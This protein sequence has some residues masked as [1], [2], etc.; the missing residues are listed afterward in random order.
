MIPPPPPP[1]FRRMAPRPLAL[2]LAAAATTLFASPGALPNSKPGSPLS[3]R[4]AAADPELA[5]ALASAEPEALA[6]ALRREILA[7]AASFADGIARYRAHPWRRPAA[8][9]PEIWREGTTRLFDGAPGS[10]GAPVLLVPSLVNRAHILDLLPD[11]SFLRALAQAGLRPMLVDWDRPGATERGWGL[12]DYIA[13]RLAR[14]LGHVVAATG[15]RPVLLG[16]CMGGL[17]AL[18]LALQ[19]GAGLAGLVLLATPWDFHAERPDLAR[20]L[21]ALAR[22]W[23]PGA[24]LAGELPVDAIQSLFAALDPLLALRKYVAFARAGE[25]AARDFVALEDWLNDGVP[26][27][28]RVARECLL[29]WYGDNSTARGDWRIGGRV[30]AP[31]DL[32]LPTLVVVPAQDRIVPPPAALPLAASIPGAASMV[33]PLGHVGMMASARAP[34][35]LWPGLVGWIRAHAAT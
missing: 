27:A 32:A 3:K 10:D 12:E 26:L 23:L 24:D 8:P 21:A 28:A 16:Y 20:A 35:L 30:V 29:G 13:G 25:A 5:A 1:P 19:R 17:L 34:S 9:W 14:C 33:P 2:H 18:P 6:A 11:R 4:L 15:R 22:H 31:A 7:R